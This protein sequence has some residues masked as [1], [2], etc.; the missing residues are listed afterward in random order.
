MCQLTRQR[1][2]TTQSSTKRR[3]GICNDCKDFRAENGSSQSYNLAWT[4]LFVATSLDSSLP[5]RPVATTT[6]RL[7]N[8]LMVRRWVVVSMDATAK[9]SFSYGSR[10]T[11]MVWECGVRTQ[12]PAP[13]RRL[14]GTSCP[15]I[16]CLFSNCSLSPAVF[17][18]KYPILGAKRNGGVRPVHRKSTCLTQSTLGPH[19][20]QI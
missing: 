1:M 7:I 5:R 16:L 6:Q 4:G 8:T 18:L 20:V 13:L 17:S 15:D 14:R 11:L 10:L 12:G 9:S 2:V 19:V 3:G